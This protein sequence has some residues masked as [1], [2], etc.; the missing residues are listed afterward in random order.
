MSERITITPLG[1]DQFRVE[2]AGEPPSAHEVAVSDEA[3]ARLGGGRMSKE[4]L[5]LASFEFLLARE[6]NTAI[7][8]RFAIE[9][10]GKYFPDYVEAMKA[11]KT[12]KEAQT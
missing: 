11:M 9:V 1:K 3:L 6:P 5:L 2:V 12:M 7:L 10:I 4:A 8:P